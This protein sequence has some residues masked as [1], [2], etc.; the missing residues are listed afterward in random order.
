[1]GVAN[2]EFPG[3]AGRAASVGVTDVTRTMPWILAGMLLIALSPNATAGIPVPVPVHDTIDDAQE[4]ARG[5]V[6]WNALNATYD[7]SAVC[8]STSTSTHCDQTTGHYGYGQFRFGCKSPRKPAAP[9]LWDAFV[10]ANGA[11]EGF[12]DALPPG[13]REASLCSGLWD[14]LNA[15]AAAYG[16]E[17]S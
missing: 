12:F 10:A 5:N 17:I 8:G 14:P 15:T 2:E 7:Q 9:A 11:T 16:P 6:A 1:M 3:A 4:Q 13:A